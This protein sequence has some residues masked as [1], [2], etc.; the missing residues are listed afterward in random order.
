MNATTHEIK[1]EI[2]LIHTSVLRIL[3]AL[4]SGEPVVPT[5]IVVDEYAPADLSPDEQ[6][7]AEA[8]EAEEALGR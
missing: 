7:A 5:P 6:H 8:I 1:K 2:D 4:N 3:T